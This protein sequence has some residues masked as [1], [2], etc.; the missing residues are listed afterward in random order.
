MESQDS[1]GTKIF[2]SYRRDDSEGVA[3]RLFDRLATQFG[4]EQIFMDVD[5][6]APGEDFIDVIERA[7]TSCDVL[8]AVIGRGWLEARD[9][10]GRRRIDNPE[11]FVRVE[12]V[13][14]LD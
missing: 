12:I 13:A 14:A 4:R 5:A 10:D 7:V 3:G 2:I 8:I 11:D 6:I 1:T 9:Q